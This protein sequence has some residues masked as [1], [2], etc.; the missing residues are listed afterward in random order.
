M[1]NVYSRHGTIMT[2]IKRLKIFNN[3]ENF[4]TVEI[5]KTIPISF[6]PTDR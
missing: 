3:I 2:R 5:V 1:N 6:W 4:S